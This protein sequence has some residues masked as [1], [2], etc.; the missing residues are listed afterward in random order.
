[1]E[2]AISALGLVVFVGL[3]FLFS[4]NRRACAGAPCS[5]GSACNSPSRCS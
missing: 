2:R 5:G 4:K 3:A 1:M